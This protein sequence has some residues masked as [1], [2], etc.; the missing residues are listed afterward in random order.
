PTPSPR[1]SPT[2]PQPEPPEMIGMQASADPAERKQAVSNLARRASDPEALQKLDKFAREDPDKSVR[3]YAWNQVHDLYLD[4]N[5]DV[6]PTVV[7]MMEH[8]TG[9][10]P[11][12]AVGVYRQK[13]ADPRA[14]KGAMRNPNPDVRE[15]AVAALA[16]VAP[17]ASDKLT[18]DYDALLAP[19]LADPA[20][21]V[22]KRAEDVRPKLPK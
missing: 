11:I 20:A 19:A 12:E 4:G 18:I 14:L 17:R 5:R 9:D 3:K 7:W 22:R 2:A 21:A 6:E 1:V 13:G 15:L 10:P 8:G 16:D